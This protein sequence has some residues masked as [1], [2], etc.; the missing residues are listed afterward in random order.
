MVETFFDYSGLD[1][2]WKYEKMETMNACVKINIQKLVN[3]KKSSKNKQ[4]EIR[5]LCPYQ[6]YLY[7][8]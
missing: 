8:V 7:E 5:T 1:S 6:L 2:T 4:T 3:L